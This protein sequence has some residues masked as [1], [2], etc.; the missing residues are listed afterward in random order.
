[1][2]EEKSPKPVT[3]TK[4]AP[5]PTVHERCIA[6]GMVRRPKCFCM[7]LRDKAT[8]QKYLPGFKKRQM[9]RELIEHE[10][11]RA[12][13]PA[14]SQYV[15]IITTPD[16]FPDPN[17][18]LYPSGAKYNCPRCKVSVYSIDCKCP[19]SR[20]NAYAVFVFRS[21]PPLPDPV[22]EPSAMQKKYDELTKS[23]ENLK[24]TH[25]KLKKEAE[26]QQ[27]ELKNNKQSLEEMKKERDSLKEDHEK[28]KKELDDLKESHE[29]LELQLKKTR[30]DEMAYLRDEPVNNQDDLKEGHETQEVKLKNNKR[31]REEMK[32]TCDESVNNQQQTCEEME[33]EC[34]DLK[35][36]H[37]ESE[38]KGTKRRE[39]PKKDTEGFKDICL[40]YI[41][42][43]NTLSKRKFNSNCVNC[44]K[45]V[46]RL[47]RL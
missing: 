38:D 4:T 31:S 32:K 16:T 41:D 42:E 5:L 8:D 43:N 3:E 45:E 10:M 33:K 26:K 25:A 19:L 14:G 22:V 40:G 46:T 29:K 28:L 47:S 12:H 30:D 34:D 9:I 18:E 35:E 24:K 1:M 36:S 15:N 20:E 39:C 27:A 2:A 37:A 13:E 23:H 7:C 6:C 17:L 11:E 21:D 44:A